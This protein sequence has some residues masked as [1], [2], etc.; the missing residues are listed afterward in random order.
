MKVIHDKELQ[1]IGMIPLI[2]DW[3][4]SPICQV[5]GCEEETNTIL[6]VTKDESPTGEPLNIGICEKHY[7]EGKVSEE[8]FRFQQVIETRYKE[9][10]ATEGS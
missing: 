7:Q 4:I 8:E 9:R 1:G 3:K 2:V 6:C 5:A 10:P